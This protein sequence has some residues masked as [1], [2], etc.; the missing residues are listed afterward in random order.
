[1]SKFVN[2][3]K[4]SWKL[5]AV[6]LLGLT[7]LLW[8]EPGYLIARGD[9]FPVY[10]FNAL[11]TIHTFVWG[12][13]NGGGSSI[14]P[15]FLL[16]EAIWYLFQSLHIPA[17]VIQLMFQIFYLLGAGIS[18]YFFTSTVYKEQKNA[19]FIA[20]IFYMFNMYMLRSRFSEPNSWLLLFLPLCL[21][22]YIRIVKKLENNQSIAK[23]AV[24]FTITS[25][26]ILSYS[27][28]NLPMVTLYP[29]SLSLMFLYCFMS[30]PSLRLKLVKNSAL[31][32]GLVL[33][34]N[35]WW[36]VPTLLYYFSPVLS[37]SVSIDVSRFSSNSV[38]SSF[39]NLFQLNGE[40][41]WVVNY[42]P[43]VDAYSNPALILL[44]F[45]PM[46]IASASLLFKSYKRFNCYLCLVILSLMF[47][48]KGLYPPLEN[49]NLFLFEHIPLLEAYGAPVSKFGIVVVVFL[50]LLI[51]S[52]ASSILEAIQRAKVKHKYFIS[53]A[54]TIFIIAVFLISA[55]PLF[56][57]KETLAYTEPPSAFTYSSYINIPDYWY[58]ASDWINSQEGNFRVLLTP[59]ENFY[60]PYNWGYYGASFLPL[61]ITKPTLQNQAL[62][63]KTNQVSELISQIYATIENNDTT[64][65]QRLLDL[66]N[67]KYILQD[68]SAEQ[69]PG[70]S[71]IIP[72]VVIKT[73]FDDQTNI[74]LVKSFGELDLYEVDN[75]NS[76]SH[77]YTAT[78]VITVNDSMDEMF[79]VIASTRG[80]P[81]IFLSNQTSPS[82]WEFL[83]SFINGSEQYAPEITF[84]EVNPTKY[85]INVTNA[86]APFFLVFSESYD[87]RWKAYV[88]PQD[89]NTNWFEAF[90]RSSVP[91]DMHFLVN[92]YANAWYI[93]PAEWGMGGQEFSITLYFQPQSLFYLGCIISGLTFGGCI[94]YLVWDWRRRI[95]TPTAKLYIIHQKKENL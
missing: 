48:Q 44:C 21:A 20:S 1:M 28:A 11:N 64:E 53:S 73:F 67:V 52:S 87:P 25:T 2:I 72:P 70:A 23:C 54:F 43:F 71:I 9:Y 77:I 74:Q 13:A 90:F 12:L 84:Q 89:G 58:E 17:N 56:T 38:R 39:L 3:F 82:Q 66:M 51:G 86:T 30:K 60:G 81:V 5:L 62:G 85:Q 4:R 22:F 92:G 88:N 69:Y 49:I 47:L 10:L 32:T 46:I 33:L 16:V 79:P 75:T 31:L 45:I 93:D 35:I 68:N 50:A 59:N 95:E 24:C 18:M 6:I 27:T 94:G 7:P 65:F 29:M 83:K 36:I 15:I 63:Y 37:A 61:L 8:F 76:L 55:F 40:A 80:K 19:P 91:D 57:Y 78:N 42:Y 26:V 14:N 41:A 34:I